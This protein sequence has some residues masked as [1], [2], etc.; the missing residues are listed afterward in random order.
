MKRYINYIFMVALLLSTGCRREKIVPV[1]D[2]TQYIS[3]FTGSEIGPQSELR[4]E[5]KVAAS[6]TSQDEQL[7]SLSPIVNG[8]TVWINNQTA[9]FHPDE[10]LKAGQEYEV[11]FNLGKA[12]QNVEQQNKEFRFKVRVQVQTCVMTLA[13]TSI[14]DDNSV[15]VTGKLVFDN[16]VELSTVKASLSSSPK[17]TP[18]IIGHELKQ[19]D[20]TF[21]NIQRNDKDYELKIKLDCKETLLE[22]TIEMNVVIPAES[23]FKLLEV[24]AVTESD[25]YI[26]AVFSQRLDE[27][28]DIEGLI[29]IAGVEKPKYIIDGNSVRLFFEEMLSETKVS[30]YKGIK[31]AD[32]KATDLNSTNTVVFEPLMP[33][34]KILSKGVIIPDANNL[35]LHFRAVNLKAVDVRVI[36]V[37]ENNILSFLQEG[38]LY[39]NYNLRRYGRLVHYETLELKPKNSCWNNYTLNM[40]SIFRRQKGAI[41]R[42][43]FSFKK[44]YSMWDCNSGDSLIEYGKHTITEEDTESYKYY[45]DNPYY[46]WYEYDYHQSLNPCH[47]TYY[48]TEKN[49]SA[50]NVINTNIGMIAKQNSEENRLWISTSNIL[51]SKPLENVHVTAYN[52]QLQAVGSGIT[53]TDGFAVIPTK[54]KAFVVVAMDGMQKT[55]LKLDSYC[56]TSLSRFD[57]EG[58]TYE[59]GLQGYIYGE[60]GV[61]RPGDTLHL[62]FVLHDPELR[63]PAGHPV[64]FEA[65]NAQGKFYNRQT[66]TVG[67]NGFYVF[68]LPTHPDDGTGLWNVKVNVGGAT[69]EKTVR[70]ESIK[71]N[72]LKISLNTTITEDSVCGALQSAWLTGATVHDLNTKVEMEFRRMKTTFKGYENG[73][74][75]DSPISTFKSDIYTLY[76]GKTDAEGAADFT[77]AKKYARDAPGML[78]AIITARVFEPGGDVSIY[79]HEKP[80]SPFK[81]YIGLNINAKGD[82]FERKSSHRFILAALTAEGKQ[83]DCQVEYRIYKIGWRW[84]WESDENNLCS[85]VS[86]TKSEI[87]AHDTVSIIGGRGCIDFNYNG[88]GHFLLVAQDVESGH[89][90]GAKFGIRYNGEESEGEEEYEDE[91]EA[92]DVRMLTFTLDK[93]QYVVGETAK[94]TIPAVAEGTALVSFENGR[95][96]LS[97]RWVDVSAKRRTEFAFDV[98]ADMAPNFYVHISLL[99]PHALAGGN[100]PI[101]LYGVV[102]VLVRNPGATLEPQIKAPEVIKPATPFLL[103][104]SEKSGRAMTY[105]LAIV[106]DGLLDLTN[107]HTPNPADEFFA[108]EALEIRTWD[109]YDAVIGSFGGKFGS[110][111]SIGGDSDGRPRNSRANRFKP[112]VK[113]LGPFAL[114]AGTTQTH[115]IELPQYVGSVRIMVVAGQNGAYG[116]A[117]VTVP[118]KAPLMLVSSLPRTLSI[119][120]EITLPVNVFALDTAIRKVSLQVSVLGQFAVFEGNTSMSL[121]FTDRSDTTVYFHFKTTSKVGIERFTISATGGGQSASETIEINVRNPNPPIINIKS[122]VLNNNESSDLEYLIGNR[123]EDAFLRL[124]TSRIPPVDVTRRLEFLFNYE[125]YCSEQITSRAL[126]LLYVPLLK[127]FNDSERFMLK[128]SVMQALHKLYTRQTTGGGFKYWDWGDTEDEWITSYAGHFLAEARANGYTVENVVFERWKKRQQ[129]LARAWSA[130]QGKAW[131]GYIQ[132]YR[133]YTL[134]VAGTPETGAM[135]RMKEDGTMSAEARRMLAAA[136]A[137]AGK[138]QVAKELLGVVETVG[139]SASNDWRYYTYGDTRRDEAVTLIALFRTGQMDEAFRRAQKLSAALSAETCMQ[140]QSSAFALM[141]MGMLAK[142]SSG[143]MNFEYSLNGGQ[144]HTFA[145]TKAVVVSDLTIDTL[146]GSLSIKNNTSG[147]LYASLISKY[148]PERD[149]LPERAENLKVEVSYRL[150]EGYKIDVSRLAQGCDFQAIIKVINTSGINDYKNLA[151]TQIIPAGWEFAATSLQ[152][153]LGSQIY[154]DIRDDRVMFY[155]DLVR[156]ANITFQVRLQSVYA[157]RYTLP[158]VRVEGMYNPEAQARTKAGVVEVLLK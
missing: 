101:R 53:D 55:Y 140:T 131:T 68:H 15:D 51:T 151:L 130:E 24:K 84:W 11:C 126:P 19:Y 14:N 1:E 48:M 77:V 153:T 21:K 25:S 123:S 137:V 59:R 128:N 70:V 145:S 7:F 20:F 139:A 85:Y 81:T 74:V 54:G 58:K 129:S 17:T 89:T 100:R 99:Q 37:Y 10:P 16:P 96:V 93:P 13:S 154:R 31:S 32:G 133:L 82:Y 5:L 28:Q 141:A 143:R 33:Q 22:K 121:N 124:E 86:S 91:G 80:Y 156:G 79:S 23:S 78:R 152:E 63:I 38:G 76:D 125:H 104:I 97:R 117:S 8:K 75:F 67:L 47:A 69:F 62:G 107:Y 135:N 52:Y 65:Y 71:S 43:I 57:T 147:V 105:T 56:E 50:I 90:T 120:E 66:T 146:N 2:L 88:W 92:S 64:T 127:D 42:L 113:H 138:T 29:T 148:K 157:G 27:Q 12:L 44:E 116:N 4:V 35:H 73:W 26:E 102:P 110:M 87:V 9:E 106:D 149:T 61:W 142:A 108:R 83:T 115:R 94:I 109:M 72:R 122:V 158:A 150:L 95:R 114:A 46:D 49:V 132:A 45:R 119:N 112:V 40:A 41:Y 111:L 34:V 103:K 30:V 36:Q 39:G 118:V 6:V 155:F 3:A 136:Y 144:N 134:A 60:R 98:T 18:I